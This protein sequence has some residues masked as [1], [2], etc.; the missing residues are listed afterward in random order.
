MQ[1]AISC[2]MK[3]ST[4]FAILPVYLT[5]SVCITKS[6]NLIQNVICF[7]V[8]SDKKWWQMGRLSHATRKLPK[9]QHFSKRGENEVVVSFRPRGHFDHFSSPGATNVP[10]PSGK[11]ELIMRANC[12]PITK[13]IGVRSL[14]YG[15]P[16]E[17]IRGC[18]NRNT[19][20]GQKVRKKGGFRAKWPI[21]LATIALCSVS[22]NVSYIYLKWCGEM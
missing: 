18:G 2:N 6:T 17:I 16:T 12:Y 4:L 3:M 1:F 20:G 5:M 13:T 10:W 11:S 15:T 22:Q 14:S 7:D 9:G 21:S 19:T 8:L